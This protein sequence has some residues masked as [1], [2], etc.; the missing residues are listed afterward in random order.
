MR[1]PRPETV[2]RR[3]AENARLSQR[4][5]LAALDSISRPPVALLLR[6][7]KNPATPARLV[8][9]AAEKYHGAISRRSFAK[10]PVQERRKRLEEIIRDPANTQAQRTEASRELREILP[11]INFNLLGIRPDRPKT[12]PQGL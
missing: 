6:L 3:L 9:L 12:E 1:Y 5:R 10:L 2:S 11:P 7:L 4:V 8:E